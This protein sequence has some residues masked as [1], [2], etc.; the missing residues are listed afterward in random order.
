MADQGIAQD[1][2]AYRKNNRDKLPQYLDEF[3][4]PKTQS[5]YAAVSSK[6]LLS[7]CPLIADKS[8]SE[9]ANADFKKMQLISPIGRS[10]QA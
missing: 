4:V 3:V 2:V 6:M 5:K 1:Y 8:L 7:E 10:L 9:I